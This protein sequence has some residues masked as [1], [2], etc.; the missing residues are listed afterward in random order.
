MDGEGAIVALTTL[1]ARCWAAH[2][3]FGFPLLSCT[4]SGIA[5][6][7]W[8]LPDQWSGRDN[9]VLLAGSAAQVRTCW[10]ARPDDYHPEVFQAR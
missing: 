5:R 2:A 8:R 9:S 4:V 3:N 6:E 10:P 1:M 7:E